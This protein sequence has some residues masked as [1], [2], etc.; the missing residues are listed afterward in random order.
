RT[1]RGR[2]A[3]PLADGDQGIFFLDPLGYLDFIALLSRARLVLTDSGGV[4]E[5]TTALSVPCLTLRECTERRVT[6]THGTNRVIGGNPNRVVAEALQTL[7][8]LP[9]FRVRPAL[10]DEWSARRTVSAVCRR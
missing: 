4:Q 7:A 6:V 3:L 8:D 2:E 10:W 1:V 9:V 5:E